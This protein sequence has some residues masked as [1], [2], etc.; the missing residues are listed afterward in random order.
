MATTWIDVADTAVKIGLGAAVAAIG[1]Y[2]LAVKNHNQVLSRDFATKKI[3]ILESACTDAEEYFNF[4]SYLYNTVSIYADFNHDDQRNQT[5]EEI[6]AVVD[7]HDKIVEALAARNRARAK[8]AL[9]GVS[10]ALDELTRY[11]DT[12]K[13][14]RDVIGRGGKMFSHQRHMEI[15]ERF[16]MHKTAFYAAAARFMSSVG[17]GH[18]A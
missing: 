7:A 8:M 18:N 15:L 16:H 17:S 14:Y 12:L 3:S 2:F 6:K 13:D 4:C 5:D 1:S 10:D 9:L 11:N